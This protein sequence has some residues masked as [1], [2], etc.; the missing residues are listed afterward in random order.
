[1]KCLSSSNK[2]NNNYLSNNEYDYSFEFPLIKVNNLESTH[3]ND[4]V[5]AEFPLGL[6]INGNYE[7]T[8]LCTPFKL[9]ELVV[10][11][12]SSRNLINYK[13][14]ILNLEIDHDKKIAYVNIDQSNIELDE[15]TLYLNEY[16]FLKANPICN[17]NLKVNADDIYK[18]MENNL[19]LSQLFKNTAGVHCISIYG[20]GKLIIACEDVARHNA[21]D[22]AIGHCILNDIP[23]NDKII[24]VSGRFSFEMMK[25]AAKVHVPI[26]VAKSATTNLVIEA[27]EKL[28]ITLVG[29]VRDKKMNIYTN[30]HRILLK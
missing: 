11:Y 29:F 23:L 26:I 4:T 15:N 24:F 16:D 1:M 12:L 27:A 9:E 7:N 22:K 14:D 2:K 18:V 19:N 20:N 3:S 6:V 21:L 25:K 5:V 10:G 13:E 30:P 17:D 28:N 8:F